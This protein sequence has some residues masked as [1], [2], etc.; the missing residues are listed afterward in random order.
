MKISQEKVN[1]YLRRIYATACPLCGNNNWTISDQVFQA[2]EFDFKGLPLNGASY[3][4]VPLT[5]TQCGNTYFINALIAG[6]IEK[7]KE[8]T[9]DNSI[10]DDNARD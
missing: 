6:L 9:T 10:S 1:S 5:C 8:T 2:L 4:I 7:P 3:P